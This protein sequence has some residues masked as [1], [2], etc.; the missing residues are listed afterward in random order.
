MGGGTSRAGGGGARA[1]RDEARTAERTGGPVR[2]LDQVRRACRV[3]HYSRR[4]ERAYAQWVK[5]FV[6]FHGKRHPSEMGAAEVSA[7]LSHLAVEGRVSA[8]TQNQA[9]AALLFLYRQ[10]LGAPALRARGAGARARAAAPARRADAGRGARAARARSTAKPRLVGALLYGVGPAAARVPAAAREGRGFR[11]RRDRRARRQGAEGSRDDAAALARGGRCARSS[12]GRA[13]CTRAISRRASARSSC[14]TR[15][16]AST[17][18]PR[19]SGAGSGSF[20]RRRRYRDARD[21]QR[22]PPPPARDGRAARGEAG[23]ARGGHREARELPHAATQLRDAPAGR[24]L[25][26]PH[27][28]G[29]ARPPRRAARP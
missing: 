21:G 4:T 9:L 6:L 23:R 22:A 3:R 5:R 25:R 8:S 18:A 1:T 15:S 12:S 16:R 28:A 14:P 7:F 17:R 19:A 2:L 13:R 24:R 26:H 27:R 20:R 10:V 29:A 11:A